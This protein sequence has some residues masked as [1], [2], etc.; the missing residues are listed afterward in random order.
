M[1]HK[2]YFLNIRFNYN[3]HLEFLYKYYCIAD[4]NQP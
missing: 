2:K 1:V 3:L 4:T